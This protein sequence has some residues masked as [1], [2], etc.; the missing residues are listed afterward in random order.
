MSREKSRYRVFSRRAA[1]IAGAQGLLAG[2]LVA[3]LYYLG[4]I[5]SDQYEMLAEDNRIS[6]RLIAPARGEI[7]DRFGVTIAGNRQD[8]RVF[9]IPEQAGDIRATL[10]R[11]GRILGMDAGDMARIER[12]IGRQK[13][14]LPVTVADGLDWQDFARINVEA[15]DL[16]GIIADSGLSRWYPQRSDAAQVVGYVGAPDESDLDGDPLLSL[17]GFRIGKRG[18][19][20]TLD[21]ELRGRAGSSRVEVNAYGRVIREIDRVDGTPGNRAVLSLDMALQS[22]IVRRL[23]EESAAAVVMDARNGELYALASTPS[24]DPNAFTL[25]I[26][27]ENWQALLKDPRKPLVD[28]CLTGQYPPGSTI[29]M[30]VAL[31]ALHH[32]VIDS[33]TKI[34]C[35]G[36]HRYGDNVWHCWEKNGHGSLA[37][38]DAIARSCD[39]YF[40]RIAAE[41]GI[42]RLAAFLSAFGLGEIHGLETGG[43]SRG[44]VPTPAWKAAT[45]GGAWLGG[46][47]LNVGI[48]Q[49]ALLATPLQLAVMTARIANGG[50]KVAPSVLRGRPPA[51]EPETIAV[52]PR[53]FAIVREGMEKVMAPRGTAY[54]YRLIGKG[55]SMAGKTGTAQ[56]RRITAEDR[57]SGRSQS[58]RPWRERHHAWFVAYGPTDDPRYAL[59]LLIE[60]GGGG[61]SAAAPVARDIMRELLLRDP[62]R[63]PPV[64]MTLAVRSGE[65]PKTAAGAET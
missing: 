11:I 46:E 30:V 3:R 47:T 40:Y 4:V 44:L 16:P 49:G 56:V 42:E 14:F 13:A 45:G 61:A 35:S 55:L 27:R 29:K 8:Y 34:Y 51:A 12:Q 62:A 24:Y 9:L 7:L 53:H 32:G 63:L 52:A 58:E 65:R 43:E 41:L 50:R 22:A 25:G 5:A 23:G 39:I 54:A 18:I 28:K 38:V 26:S 59:S 21:R 64:D 60:H 17:P 6:I 31:A 1:L 57:E 37:M 19:E 2:G 15:P 10:E 36:K 33:D 48:G 20:R